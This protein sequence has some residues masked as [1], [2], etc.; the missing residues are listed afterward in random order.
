[1]DIIHQRQEAAAADVLDVM[2]DAPSYSAVRALLAVMERKGLVKHRMEGRKYV[3][4]PTI[5]SHKVARAALERVMQTFFDDSVEKAMAALLNSRD[6][7]LSAAE[8]KRLRAMIDAAKKK[9]R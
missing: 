2:D 9:G 3:Y 4:L 8:Y 6:G 5:P 1:M 7:D